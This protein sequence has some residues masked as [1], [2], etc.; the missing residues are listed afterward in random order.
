[1]MGSVDC[2]VFASFQVIQI[3][4]RPGMEAKA[5]H[6]QQCVGMLL[7]LYG[8]QPPLPPS[9]PPRVTAHERRTS[10]QRLA[11]ESPL[12]P[13]LNLWQS[14]G[15]SGLSARKA[16]SVHDMGMWDWHRHKSGSWDSRRI[17]SHY[18]RKDIL[19][20]LISSSNRSAADSRPLGGSAPCSAQDCTLHLNLGLKSAHA[21]SRA[22]GWPQEGGGGGCKSSHAQSDC[23]SYH[24]HHLRLTLGHL[25]DDARLLCTSIPHHLIWD[26]A[27][28]KERGGG[29]GG[30]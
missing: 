29:G 7:C 4:L 26:S 27:Q 17:Q 25:V 22:W 8:M 28:G 11:F 16:S 5:T 2:G 10:Q 9:H 19:V 20:A 1:M 18:E 12:L 13:H 23:W 21:Q 30:K 24:T 15:R 6:M 3:A 14:Q